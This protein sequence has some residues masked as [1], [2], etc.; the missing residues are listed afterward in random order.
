MALGSKTPPVQYLETIS[1]THDKALPS[2]GGGG[3]KTAVQG[4]GTPPWLALV[5]CVDKKAGSQPATFFVLQYRCPQKT[6]TLPC[7]RGSCL[8]VVV[9]PSFKP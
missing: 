6:A 4:L 8:L 3:L 9:W 5:P 2:H 7:V 1:D